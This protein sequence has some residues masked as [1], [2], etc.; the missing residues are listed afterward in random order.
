VAIVL[1][2]PSFLLFV[3]V[4]VVVVVV[5]APEFFR[6]NLGI[7]LSF[8]GKTGACGAAGTFGRTGIG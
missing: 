8:N 3:V 5:V 1:L 6:S 2:V 7:G 4:V